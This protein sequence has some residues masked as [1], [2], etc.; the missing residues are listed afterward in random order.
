MKQLKTRTRGITF[1][2]ERTPDGPIQITFGRGNTV[3]ITADDYL[4][5]INHFRGQ[6]V[7]LGTS[8]DNPPHGSVGKWVQENVTRTAI[9]S[10]L[11]PILVHEG[12]AV[13]VD[14]STLR[15]AG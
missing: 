7:A 10:Y 9:A 4:H 12:H 5:L 3:T 1:S 8:R 6:V 11:G 15:F 2:Y 14:D 13:W